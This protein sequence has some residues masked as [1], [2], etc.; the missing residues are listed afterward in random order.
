[1]RLSALALAFAV[2]KD[3]PVSSAANAST[4]L[5]TNNAHANV[6]I[7]EPDTGMNKR[8]LR[9]PG[10][11]DMEWTKTIS[12]SPYEVAKASATSPASTNASN[13]EDFSFSQISHMNQNL[14][15][16]TI[17]AFSQ[18]KYRPWIPSTLLSNNDRGEDRDSDLNSKSFQTCHLSTVDPDLGVLRSKGHDSSSSNSDAR[19]CLSER[20]ICMLPNVIGYDA[21]SSVAQGKDYF[22]D[23][24]IALG[25]CVPVS[26]LHESYW[27]GNSKSNW[28]FHH[29]QEHKT[30]DLRNS[31]LFHRALQEGEGVTVTVEMDSSTSEPPPGTNVLPPYVMRR[32]TY[33]E[34]SLAWS[35]GPTTPEQCRQYCSEFG[36]R[37][38]VEPM[39]SIMYP[40]GN[41]NGTQ[42]LPE[43]TEE[44]PRW[45]QDVLST[46]MDSYIVRYAWG[47]N[48][49]ASR[50]PIDLQIPMSCWDTSKVTNVAGAFASRKGF[51]WRLNCWNT[52]GVTDM[53]EM[54]EYASSFNQD[55]GLWDTSRVTDMHQM[56]YITPNFHQHSVS[57]WDTGLV[58]D[59]SSMF[60]AARKFD[61][62]IGA[63]NTS[64]VT[65]LSYMFFAARS[66]N[67]PVGYW[68]VSGVKDLS[69]MFVQANVFDQDL[70]EWTTSSVSN[71]Q[72]TFRNA[73]SFNQPLV[74]WDVSS[75]TNM[76]SMFS[77]ARSFDQPL[78]A[79]LQ[80]QGD[81]NHSENDLSSALINDS[82]NS[83]RSVPSWD[84]SSVTN[85]KRMFS[86]AT[87]FNQCLGSWAE[88]LQQNI[89]ATEDSE[90][91]GVDRSTNNNILRMFE[92][93][94]CP[95][96]QPNPD[97]TSTTST[98]TVTT[99]EDNG[100]PS[101]SGPWC[102]G[103]SEGCFALE[104]MKLEDGTLAYVRMSS[105]GNTKPKG[106]SI[107][108][109]SSSKSV[110]SDKS[111]KSSKSQKRRK[112]YLRVEGKGESG[113]D[114]KN[115]SL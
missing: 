113:L 73:Y 94:G 78:E 7:N 11:S 59:M 20:E 65:D 108:G 87:S 92:K 111:S 16:T 31:M 15:K 99:I 91:D 50:C 66:F 106:S 47:L 86:M 13:N 54:F 51:D 44:N 105:L 46:C 112:R 53:Y 69:G 49:Y 89:E 17:R 63:W 104:T 57:N 9:N 72:Y 98:V 10:P 70:S 103:P 26:R 39:S 38:V 19:G 61:G 100:T 33:L 25:I 12:S 14:Q 62:P 60:G 6:N 67:K 115:E 40:S 55:I 114:S 95:N 35:E 56:F 3:I 97:L 32:G 90:H 8:N 82:G 22:D 24:D 76:A 68:D 48:G 81:R 71:T 21:L 84:L 96:H 93:T 28:H 30:N 45:F 52:S 88:T 1:M 42:S 43:E 74:E 75:V 58:R 37:P 64:S 101:S 80:Q 2:G 77:G 23:D 102:R 34:Q 79:E 27:H 18:L 36:P 4:I 5:S 109:G 29:H 107:G 83:E 85:M 110:K 41:A